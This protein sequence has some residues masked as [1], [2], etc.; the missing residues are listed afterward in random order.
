M[1]NNP[2]I[3]KADH[4]KPPNRVADAERRSEGA[5][6]AHDPVIAVQA[7]FDFLS[8]EYRT[9]FAASG[10]TLF[11]SPLWLD[12]FYRTLVPAVAA[13][14]VIVTVRERS[15]GL[16]LLVLA[17]VRQKSLGARIMQPADLGIS[18]YNAVVISSE[19]FET[20]A[21]MAH[22]RRELRGSLLPFDVFLFRKQRPESPDIHRL[23]DGMTVFEN[24]NAAH[25]TIIAGDFDLWERQVLS[26]AT[27]KGIARKRRN[28][29]K[30][31]GTLIFSIARDAAEI[32]AAFQFLRD[33]RQKRF[34]DDLLS[35][36]A[37]FDFYRA[38]A[39]SALASGSA[40]TYVGKIDGRI[41]TVDFTL[42]DQNRHLMLLAAYSSDP[43][44]QKYSLGLQAI[45]DQMRT[46]RAA[47]I[48]I[49]D[50]TIG[51]EDY[52]SSFGATRVP[53]Y[54]IT[55]ANGLIGKLALTI[56]RRGSW[57]KTIV[58][59]LSSKLH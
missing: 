10:A 9:L 39:H 50:L 1:L 43:A 44:H 55:L 41:V 47:G 4:K 56:Y 11:Q 40:P 2:M 30:E 23:I 34:A 13:E 19:V 17:C 59:K 52:K 27:R 7:D 33:E 3:N 51:D 18:D 16:L 29:E 49:M 58:K 22:F 42:A 15:S 14:P 46:R 6:G 21:G 37:Y 32:D 45:L 57:L 12:A 36:A 31:V 53:L 54:N 26:K 8:D 38:V 28:L 48:S 24:I 20:L 35:E 5:P 25:E